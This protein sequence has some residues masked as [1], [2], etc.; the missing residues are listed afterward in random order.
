MRITRAL[1]ALILLLVTFNAASGD[2]PTRKVSYDFISV[3]VELT[4]DSMPDIHGM[5]I[6]IRQT[7]G[8][9]LKI[10][11]KNTFKDWRGGV[12]RYGGIVHMGSDLDIITVATGTGSGLYYL[13]KYRLLNGVATLIKSEQIY[14]WGLRPPNDEFVTGKK[15]SLVLKQDPRDPWKV[16]FDLQ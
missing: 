4:I 2:L 5:T 3:V 13:H 10:L 9:L 1:T 14:E 7:D 16:H 6:S 12:T 11:E 8:H 15:R